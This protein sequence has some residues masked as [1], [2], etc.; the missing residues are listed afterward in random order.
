MR[1]ANRQGRAI[2][3]R[4]GDAAHLE[5]A[6]IETATAGRFSS[7]PAH[8]FE[9][10]DELAA[11]FT[12][13]GSAVAGWE[14][15]EASH[16]GPPS[17]S[18][19]QIFAIGVNYSAHADETG[20]AVPEHPMVFTKFASA[21]T[22]PETQVSLPTET[23]DWEIE[24]VVVIGRQGANIPADAAWDH[25]AGLTVGQD[26]SE[27]TLQMAGKFPQFS[28]A[29]SYPGFA[30]TGP[31]VVSLDEFDDL[32]A[33]PLRATVNG[34]V[35]QE[36]STAQ[37]IFGIPTLIERISAVCTLYPGDLIFTGT[38]DGVGMGRTPPVYLKPGD[39]LVSE[40]PGVGILRQTFE[41]N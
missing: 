30:P 20:I 14:P 39:E 12:E 6:D 27:R 4:D 18:P 31:V 24:L 34:R 35:V 28:L 22:G 2:L 33:I 25:I 26:I 23:V 29:K 16:L 19:R 36:G 7:D 10:W 8:A 32:N 15:I 1:I 13:S 41:K 38:P 9:R 5:A 17:P 11:W 21:L 37:L 40:V 3:V